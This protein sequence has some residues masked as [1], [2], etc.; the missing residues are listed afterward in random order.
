MNKNFVQLGSQHTQRQLAL[1]WARTITLMQDN[2]KGQSEC[3]HLLYKGQQLCWQRHTM[4]ATAQNTCVDRLNT[5]GSRDP[6]SQ[7][8]QTAADTRR[9]RATPAKTVEQ[10]QERFKERDGRSR[11]STHIANRELWEPVSEF[12]FSLSLLTQFKRANCACVNGW[13]STLEPWSK[14]GDG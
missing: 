6:A 12:L 8:T 10:K 13:S 4:Y 11:N 3:A 1:K 14:V 5:E 2:Q 7:L 9:E